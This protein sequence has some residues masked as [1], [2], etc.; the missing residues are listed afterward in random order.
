MVFEIIPPDEITEY[1]IAEV[2]DI[3]SQVYDDDAQ[4]SL[5]RCMQFFSM[6]KCIYLFFRDVESS[7]IVGNVNF[8][9]VTDECYN[10]IKSGDFIERDIVS[11]MILPDGDSVYFSGITIRD[12]YRNRSDL[13]R[14]MLLEFIKRTNGIRRMVA[15]AVT[16]EGARLCQMFKMSKV[17]ISRHGSEI[18]EKTF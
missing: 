8:M 14:L 10:M 13:L 4:Q 7:L 2:L 16:Q 9:P 1:D 15:D 12:S 17:C 18:Y 3:E 11:E 6:N 5:E